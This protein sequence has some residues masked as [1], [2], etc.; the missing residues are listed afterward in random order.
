[1]S[2]L[3][4]LIAS[5]MWIALCIIVFYRLRKWNKMLEDL[6]EEW[7]QLTEEG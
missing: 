2:D 3:V 6:Y 4:Q 7:K 5:L 1:M